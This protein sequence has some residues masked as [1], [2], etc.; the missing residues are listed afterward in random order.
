[1]TEGSLPDKTDMRR[2]H[3]SQTEGS[4][5]TTEKDREKDRMPGSGEGTKEM[6][7]KK[8]RQKNGPLLRRSTNIFSQSY[9]ALKGLALQAG[10]VA[11]PFPVSSAEHI[12]SGHSRKAFPGPSEKGN[13]I[14][15]KVRQKNI[16]PITAVLEKLMKKRYCF[17]KRYERSSAL[18]LPSPPA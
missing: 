12:L 13:T 11:P 17:S 15:P 8:L 18:P 6:G 16:F 2:Q 3:L 1:M 9:V 5:S 7:K 14:S 4:A 10:H